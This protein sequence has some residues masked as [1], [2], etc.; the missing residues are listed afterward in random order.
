MDKILPVYNIKQFR[1]V[2]DENNFYANELIP[3]LTEHHF[4][5]RPHKHD[6]YLLLLF[7]K[8]SGTHNVDF[9]DYPIKPGTVFMLNPGQVHSWKLSKDIDGYVFFHTKAFYD[10]GFTSDQVK[11]YPFFNSTQSQPFLITQKTTRVKIEAL[12]LEILNEYKQQRI[13][14]FSKLHALVSILYIEITRLYKPAKEAESEKYLIS[15][16]KLEA[17]IDRDFKKIKFPEEYASLM[18]ITERHL[19]RI[20]KTCLNKTPTELISDRV[21]LE[22]K[23]MLI[24]ST[25]TIAEV[26]AELGYFDSSY[27]SRLFKKKTG[28]TPKQFLT[29]HQ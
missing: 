3:H 2:D 10:E 28:L 24:H 9:T 8:G 16:Q 29:G 7:T 17:L 11:N 5:A 4:T 12:F 26:A 1:H 22:A 23:R 13:L 20:T 19:N 6:F 14:K 15:L 27:F 25:Y 21:I 18:N